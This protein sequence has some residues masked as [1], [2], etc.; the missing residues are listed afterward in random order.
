[1]N[2][3]PL[4]TLFAACG[5]ALFAVGCSSGPD[6]VLVSSPPP[7]APTAEPAPAQ[8]VVVQPQQVTTN[9][10]PP[11][12]YVVVQS[13]PAAQPP[14]AVPARPSQQHQWLP[15]YY[16]WQNNRYE[17]MA[18]HWEVPPRANATW[19]NPRWVAENGN[20]RFYEGYWN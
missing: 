18:G 7:R 8:V 1:M 2:T 3:Q 10:M 4:P 11:N 14:E 20:Y 17:W 13:P 16:V 12:S 19:V 6:S 15:G 5:L 9:T